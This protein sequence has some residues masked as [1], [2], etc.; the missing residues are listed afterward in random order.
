MLYLPLLELLLASI[1]VKTAHAINACP[2]A[3]TVYIGAGGVRYR[4]CP[5]TDLTGG[6]NTVT[7]NVASV[8][9]CAQLCDK[10][11][12][13]FKAIYDTKTLNCHFKALTGL[14]WVASTGFTAVQVEQINIARCPY[15]ETTYTNN[16]VSGLTCLLV[17]L[18]L[19]Y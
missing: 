16:A 10:S 1:L 8:T 5:D 6:S 4:I 9:A 11:M 18:Y 19:K 12:N 14:T 17:E 7:A 3:D 13:C 2:V 15:N